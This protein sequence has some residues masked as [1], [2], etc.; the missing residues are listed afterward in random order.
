MVYADV[1]VSA[2]CEEDLM[3]FLKLC[4]VIQAAG[5]KGHCS[6]LNVVVDGDGSGHYKFKVNGTKLPSNYNWNE[7]NAIWLGE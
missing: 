6:D 7:K 3:S 1:R 2:Q 4:S 5:D